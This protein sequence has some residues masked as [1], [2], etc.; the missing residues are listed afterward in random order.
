MRR[1]SPAK[2]PAWP[3]DPE[4]RT[5]PRR[6]REEAWRNGRIDAIGAVEAG[7]TLARKHGSNLEETRG[8]LRQERRDQRDDR[9][10]SGWPRQRMGSADRRG[11]GSVAPW[12]HG[13]GRGVAHPA[14]AG[15]RR[16]PPPRDRALRRTGPV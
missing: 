8:A 4:T 11:R 10:G 15:C 5:L 2:L 16:T 14:H 6:I 12:G 1:A 13:R 9:L 3:P 7:R